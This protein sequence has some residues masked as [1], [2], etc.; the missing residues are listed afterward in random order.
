MNVFKKL[1]LTFGLLGCSISPLFSTS[2][3]NKQQYSVNDLINLYTKPASQKNGQWKSAGSDAIKFNNFLANVKTACFFSNLDNLINEMLY[4]TF[5]FINTPSYTFNNFQF[6][7]DNETL[8]QLYNN[9]VVDFSFVYSSLTNVKTLTKDGFNSY[10]IV[11]SSMLQVSFKH[12]HEI[13]KTH[14]V[15]AGTT[16]T[17]IGEFQEDNFLSLNKDNQEETKMLPKNPSEYYKYGTTTNQYKW[18]QNFPS[19]QN[20]DKIFGVIKTS[21]VPMTVFPI[22]LD[23]MT[24]STWTNYIWTDML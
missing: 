13:S 9:N 17:Y 6:T 16:I 21:I 8:I 14:A 22:T 2:C 18:R 15:P 3:V 7:N 12:S 23:Y 1:S 11:F 5:H 24:E 20:S 19:F 4:D 10:S